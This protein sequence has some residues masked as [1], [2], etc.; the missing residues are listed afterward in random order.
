MSITI[1]PETEFLDKDANVI[2]GAYAVGEV[3]DGNRI[4]GNSQPKNEKM[5][6]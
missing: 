5:V 4:G 6:K 1:K 2:L 3:C